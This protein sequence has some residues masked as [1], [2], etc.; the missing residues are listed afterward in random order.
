M[1]NCLFC[2]IAAK[3]IPSSIVHEDDDLL[4]FKDIHPAAPVH[5]LIIPKQH[6]AT[7]SDTTEAH[8]AV[9][10]KMLALA[11]KLAAEHGCAVH[12]GVDGKPG[13]GFKT[14]INSGPDGGQEVYHL[15]MHLIGGP[16]PWRGQH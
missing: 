15:H 6:V 14:L 4:A 2:K 3:Q 12:H 16:H 13:G 9:L 8:T 7:L 11:P 1:E 10:G 5:L